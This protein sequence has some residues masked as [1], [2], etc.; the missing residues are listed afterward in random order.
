MLTVFT[1][2]YYSIGLEKFSK[3]DTSNVLRWPYL[4]FLI[5]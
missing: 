1:E 5:P 3:F 4:K 2:D